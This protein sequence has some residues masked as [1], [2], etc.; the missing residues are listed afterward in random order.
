MRPV[1]LK[2]PQELG[3]QNPHGTRAKYMGGCHCESCRKANCAYSRQRDKLNRQGL[4]N[5][6]VPADAARRRLLALSKMHIGKRAIAAAT[7]IGVSILFEIRNGTR[8]NLRQE[9]ERRLM[10]FTAEYRSD[11]S[12]VPAG[13]TWKLIDELV[14]EGFTKTELSVRLGSKYRGLQFQKDRVVA[15]TA[16]RV[17]KLHKALAGTRKPIPVSVE[18]MVEL[19]SKRR[20]A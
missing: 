5:R 4:T 16:M 15:R 9:T 10:G 2:S 12:F 3:A 6:I 1:D 20:Q 19:A 11:H 8:K 14:E 17:E 7:G 18:R 13:S